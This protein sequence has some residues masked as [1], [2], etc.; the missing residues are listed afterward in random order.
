M[1][2]QPKEYRKDER[3]CFKC[4]K[5]GHL[6]H[7][8]RTRTQ[9]TTK[10]KQGTSNNKQYK[11]KNMFLLELNNVQLYDSWLIDSG[12]THHICKHRDWF[13]NYKPIANE[14]IYSANNNTQNNLKAI[15]IDDINIKTYVN[16]SNFD[17]TLHNV[18]HVP[19]VRRNLLSVS[20]I[21]NK[22]KRLVIDNHRLSIL[23]KRTKTIVRETFCKNGL[24][25]VRARITKSTPNQIE[26]HIV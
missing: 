8:C 26:T 3:K 23:N 10:W 20:Q 22:Q 5:Q 19:N 21:E 2:H 12:A 14:I 9:N 11:Q 25:I 6:A 7:N 13:I 15:G 1:S 16:N 17:I 18:H 24:Y 4:G